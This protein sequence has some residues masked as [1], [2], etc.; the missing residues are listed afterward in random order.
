MIDNVVAKLKKQAEEQERFSEIASIT[1]DK[2]PIQ[3]TWFIWNTPK[4]ANK[5]YVLYVLD[6]AEKENILA[7]YCLEGHDP[8]Y[9]FALSF[10]TGLLTAP[11]ISPGLLL[12]ITTDEKGM[13]S[14]VEAGWTELE[15]GEREMLKEAFYKE[16]KTAF[17]N[18][19]KKTWKKNTW[20]KAAVAFHIAS[21]GELVFGDDDIEL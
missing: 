11:E 12:K 3:L 8:A 21:E 14:S 9:P 18:A 5:S 17:E 7:F 15:E 20:A 16:L 6:K 19:K 4:Q 13:I 10:A 1:Q 2:T